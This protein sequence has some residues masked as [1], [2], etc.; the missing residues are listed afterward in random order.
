MCR[1]LQ[2]TPTLATRPK[3]AWPADR[4]EQQQAADDDSGDP[5]QGRE[6]QPVPFH[7]RSTDS[8]A[9]NCV[10]ADFVFAVGKQSRSRARRNIPPN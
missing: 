9:S 7:V 6:R 5:D 8:T 3:S 4:G 1:A 2:V 10:D